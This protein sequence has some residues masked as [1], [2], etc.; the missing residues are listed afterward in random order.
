MRL[1]LSDRALGLALLCIVTLA[2]LLTAGRSITT[3]SPSAFLAAEA[4]RHA[5]LQGDAGSHGHMHEDGD[6]EERRAGH[7]HGHNPA[8]H[9][10]DAPIGLAYFRV[11]ATSVAA[12]WQKGA[13]VALSGR[14][15]MRL[16]RPPDHLA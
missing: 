14:R 3:H 5:T 13:P 11:A 8:D 9:S 7:M 16:D 6:K 4:E 2:M 1:L 10:H 15:S 12:E